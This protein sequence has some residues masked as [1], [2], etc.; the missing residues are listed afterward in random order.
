[1]SVMA[2]LSVMAAFGVLWRT[3]KSAEESQFV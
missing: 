3:F 2:A 1:M